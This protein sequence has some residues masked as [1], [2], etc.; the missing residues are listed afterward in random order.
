MFGQQVSPEIVDALLKQK[1]D[2]IIQKRSVCIMFLDIRNFTPFAAM[3]TPE[4]IIAY[5]NAVF[6]FMIDIINGH[7]G[8]INQ[9]L[10]DSFTSTFGAPLSFGNDCRNVVE[11]ALAII[12]RLKQENDNGNIPPTR[13]GIGIHAGE[14][15]AGNVGSSLR[16]QYSI[17][18]IE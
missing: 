4:E 3:H 2:P 10:G 13:V 17:T 5:Q 18:G 7:H 12:A 9:F 1:P 15:V 11:A 8:I 16:K 14:V 6:G